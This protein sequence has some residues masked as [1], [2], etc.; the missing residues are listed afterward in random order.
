[1]KSLAEL[2][3]L[4]ATKFGLDPKLVACI[5]LQE[6]GG[7]PDAYRFEDEFYDRYLRDKK[8]EDLAGFVPKSI[9]TFKSEKRAR[10]CSWGVMQVMGETARCVGFAEK[11]L[12][13][14]ALSE[15]N[16]EIGC[17]YLSQLF[18]KAGNIPGLSLLEK[19]T[20]VL[21]RWNGSSSYPPLVLKRMKAEE[22]KVLL[23]A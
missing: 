18:T 7:D 1:M 3:R 12:P 22:W 20:W 10:S 6:S 15:F 13:R 19:T 17:K 8:R 5:I 23:D 11:W 16:V 9:P 4:N 14:L 2:I 21:M